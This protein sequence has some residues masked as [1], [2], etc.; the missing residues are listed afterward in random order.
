MQLLFREDLFVSQ[1]KLSY[2][3]NCLEIENAETETKRSELQKNYG[4]NKRSYLTNLKDF[5]IMTQLPQD[6]MLTLLEGSLQYELRILLLIYIKSKDFTLE[7]LNYK[8]INFD[9]D[10]SEIGDRFGP[11]HESVFTGNER[12]KLKYNS[13]QSKLFL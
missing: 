13:P 11:L 9:F 12:Y 4:I 2:E 3:A 10:F 8:I 7:E 5:D 1:T 6:L